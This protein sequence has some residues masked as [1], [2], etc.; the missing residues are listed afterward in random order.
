MIDPR[1]DV[2]IVV[3][4]QNDF[5]PGG[6]LAVPAGEAVVAPCN[7][8]VALFDHVI[9]TQ[10]WH[11]RDH[12]SFASSHRDKKPFDAVMLPD[13]RTQL[14]WP[15]HCLQGSKGAEI[16]ASLEAPHAELIIRKG[17][18]IGL[19][20]YSAFVEADGQTQTGLAGYLR[21]RNLRRVIVC[22]LATDFC[23][24]WS[25]IDAARAGFETILVADATRGIDI[26]GS[27]A[28]A[29]TDMSAAGVTWVEMADIKAG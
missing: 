19:D 12:V 1:T 29:F 26:D 3:D 10:D 2:L 6:P 25:A 16:V 24:G 5:L 11:P 21:E 4:L 27:M 14:L 20:S 15:D 13:G 22:G 8:L 18:R 9:L 17:Y 23:A 28:R 7:Q